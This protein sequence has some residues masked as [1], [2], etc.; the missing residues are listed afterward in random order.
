MKT[1]AIFAL[2]LFCL[3]TVSMAEDLKLLQPYLPKSEE[4]VGEVNQLGAEPE[5][6]K[7]A[8]RMAEAIK[9]EQAWFTQHLQKLNLKPGQLLPYHPKLGLSEAEYKTLMASMGK[10]KLVKTGEVRLRFERTTDGVVLRCTGTKLPLDGL[11]IDLSKDAVVTRLATLDTRSAIDQKNADSPLGRW[12]GL[13]W[14]KETQKGPND[15][16]SEKLAIG[17]REKDSKGILYYDLK[18]T[19]QQVTTHFVVLYPIE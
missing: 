17:R 5:I 13:Q 18:S 12:T 4:V 9:A 2:V 16:F 15:L 7:L 19:A 14:K 1:V 8:Q 11:V 6:E 10:L 3:T